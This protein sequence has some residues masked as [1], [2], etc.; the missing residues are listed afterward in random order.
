[1]LTISKASAGA[2]KTFLLTKTYIDMLFSAKQAKNA[3]RRILAVTFT[4]KATAE[5]KHR[6]V[7]EMSKLANGEKSDFAP[8]L[9]TKYGLNAE[10]LQHQAQGIL[11]NLLQDYSAFAVSTIDSFFQQVIRAFSRELGLSGKYNIELDTKA[12]QQSAVDDFFQSLSPKEDKWIFQALLSII[13]NNLNE[14]TDWNPQ[15]NLLSLSGELFMESVME[16]QEA[17]L[18]FVN[19]TEAVANYQKRIKEVVEEYY[20]NYKQVAQAISDY[21]H[22]NGLT[23]EIFSRGKDVFAPIAYTPAIIETKLDKVPAY[24]AKFAQGESILKSKDKDNPALQIHEHQL[25]QLVEPI[26]DFYIGK[27]AK[28]FRTARAIQKNFFYLILLG[29]VLECIAQKNKELNRLPISETNS[30]LNEVIRANEQSPFVYEKIGTRIRH[31][32]IDEF[33]D[34]S[35]MQWEN[36]RPLIKESLATGSS[37]LVVGDV[38]QSIYRFRNSDYTLMLHEIEKT[39]QQ[40]IH[41]DLEGNWRSSRCVVEANNAVFKALAHAL[42]EEFAQICKQDNSTIR[43]VYAG[44]EQEPMLAKKD[45]VPDGYVQM[46]FTPAETDKGW[47]KLWRASILEQL[48]DLIA[49]IQKRGIPLGRVA[50]LVRNNKDTFPIAQTLIEAG[51]QV[52]SNEGLK[53]SSSPAVTL[54]ILSLQRALYPEDQILATEHTYF[55][56]LLNVVPI[57]EALSLQ[58]TLLEQVDAI[59]KHYRLDQLANEKTYLLALQDYVYEYM[60]KHSSD[61][62]AFLT[63]WESFGQ[64]KSLTMQETTDA[65]QIVSIHKS[66]GLEYDVVIIPF[67]DWDKSLSQNTTRKDILW[68]EPRGEWATPPLLPI[69]SSDKLLQTDFANDF[70]GELLNLYLDNLN[71]TYVA[72]TRAK[73]ELYIFAPIQTG[74]D[75]SKHMGG[76]LYNVLN[77]NPC[78]MTCAK[79]DETVTFSL[80]TPVQC[81]ATY[82]EKSPT[83]KESQ[84]VHSQE[85]VWTSND[86]IAN[87]TTLRLPSRDFFP[88]DD[89]PQ[90]LGKILHQI[91]QT[92]TQQGEEAHI[93]KRMVQAGIIQVG[94]EPLIAQAMQQ[95]WALLAQEKKTDWFEGDRYTVLNERDILLPDGNI[96]RPDRILLDKQAHHAI[97]IDYKFG[98]HERELYTKQVRGYMQLLQSMGYTTE[99]HLIY[100]TLNK[101]VEV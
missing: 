42:S 34:T 20:A 81:K 77:A 91:L 92:I 45:N 57:E 87:I 22:T 19:D 49:D 101:I 6:I 5:M 43:D 65:I 1:M 62:F 84:P 88:S 7:Q 58:G 100:V 75:T 36:F 9:Q 41:N 83:N 85:D 17:I 69:I 10:Q 74:Q 13:E 93:I 72:F 90:I 48:P 67:C 71:L 78:G 26:Y 59:I 82:T 21:L 55:C 53:L 33:Q 16:H 66:K 61:L 98:S 47:Q 24:F 64:D 32:L 18:A 12:I 4:K 94:Q 23:A 30:L 40:A 44:N 80:G 25:R 79:V 86:D 46:Q 3:H 31:F 60:N 99:G 51:Y 15:K 2:G 54:V 39:F 56:Q 95:F 27:Q 35:K 8:D 68:L 38:K 96:R 14:G 89:N 28:R 63:W 50:C 73:H 11:Y 76:C 70:L 97:I 52:M 29:K 37:N